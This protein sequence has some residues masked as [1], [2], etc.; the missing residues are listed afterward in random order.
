MN[1]LIF[2]E[3][4]VGRA[5]PYEIVVAILLVI[6]SSVAL[7]FLY[8]NVSKHL[9]KSKKDQQ[10]MSM[11]Q[12]VQPSGEKK[13]FRLFSRN[14]DVHTSDLKGRI[15]YDILKSEEGDLRVLYSIDID[16]FRTY[17][18]KFD[19]KALDKITN[20]I[21]KRLVK[22]ADKRDV[23]GHLGKDRF[24][25]Y[26]T[27]E[28][29]SE[30]ITKTAEDLLALIN[31]PLKTEDIQLTA[32]M[33][34]CVF[35]YDG[36]D[37]D[38]LIKNADLAVYVAKKEGKARYNLYSEDMIEKERFNISY[39]EEIK[40]AI[41]ND[42]F[43]LYYQ[44]IV[45][46]KTGKI[47]G[48]ESLL[49]WNHPEMGILPPGKFLNVMD[50]TGDITWFGMWGFE[51]VVKKYNDWLKEFRIRQLF[52]SINLSPKQ[53]LIEDLARKF[54]DVTTKYSMKPDN[55]AFEVLDYF[56]VNRNEIAMNNLH[57]F[58]RYG[59]RVAIDDNGDNFEVVNHMEDIVANIYKLP[60]NDLLMVMDDD[61]ITEDIMRVIKA[62]KD[63]HKIV[64]AEGIENTEMLKKMSDWGIRFM[65]G[66]YFS[67]PV[68]VD[69]AKEMVK[70]SPWNL[71]SFDA[72]T[73]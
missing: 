14:K 57:E 38:G 53:L 6:I 1:Y 24:V 12:E 61:P 29:N 23:A 67:E 40:N 17:V 72:Y 56:T 3:S 73:E 27:G 59:F 19:Q 49:R 68:D 34:V 8:K 2:L 7:F 5:R 32:S 43:L 35:P 21:E 63:N 33:G 18:E 62:A 30:T 70:K 71:D 48:L 39:Y 31:E 54:Y 69:K 20:E 41:D 10:A 16:D 51:R 36:I 64:I 37:A 25:Y 47:I 9:I 58:R 65:Q 46:V 44:P 42:E 66:Y 55:F 22:Y 45:D 26:Y 13:E 4:T 15:N 11:N 50:L 52:I 60:R 28:C